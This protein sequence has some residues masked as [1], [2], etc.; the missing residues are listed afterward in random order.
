M[1]TTTLIFLIVLFTDLSSFCQ[2]WVHAKLEPNYSDVNSVNGAAVDEDGNLYMAGDFTNCYHCSGINGLFIN[3]YDPAGNL[4]WSDT[5]HTFWAHITGLFITAQ[6]RL[7]VVGRCGNGTTNF[8]GFTLNGSYP[9]NIGFAGEFDLNG[10]CIYATTL[11]YAPC[12]IKYN[13]DSSM[14]IAGECHVTFATSGYASSTGYFVGNFESFFSTNWLETVTLPS[15]WAMFNPIIE[16]DSSGNIYLT[17]VYGNTVEKY[18]SEGGNFVCGT[19]G[20]AMH[21]IGDNL[22]HAM[23][24][25][26]EKFSSD[27]TVIWQKNFIP[28]S[29][30][31]NI[32]TYKGNILVSG[33]FRDSIQFGTL[34]YK[35]DS[36]GFN[37]LYVLEVDTNGNEIKLLIAP[38]I[39]SYC[40]Y[41][42]IQTCQVI[43]RGLDVY[44]TG[45]MEGAAAFGSDTLWADCADPR[46]VFHAMVS[47]PLAIVSNFSQSE[48]TIDVYPN[49][50]DGIFNIQFGKWRDSE[51]C[52]YDVL[53]NCILQKDSKVCDRI[54][55]SGQNKGMYFV[56]V[57]FEGKRM[58]EKI[59]LQ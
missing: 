15:P 57:V 55:L 44:I 53:G 59:V 24:S 42:Q 7:C 45:E 54:D 2:T 46:Y 39:N 49:P 34:K 56:E 32:A 58:V 37:H 10:N 52:V 12:A 14:S 6:N 25:H 21:C 27:G 20:P 22:Y 8:F 29:I 40:W 3:K 43:T 4:I 13:K 31:N 16:S 51:I 9:Y 36:I 23:S 33:F 30:P 5:L 47:T 41:S 35:A 19:N 1:K 17:D 26:L 38:H 28:W 18:N 50:S 48:K 11:P